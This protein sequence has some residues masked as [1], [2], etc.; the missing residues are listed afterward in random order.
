MTVGLFNI[1]IATIFA[2]EVLEGSII[3]INYRSIIHNKDDWDKARK[4]ESLRAVTVAAFLA[5]FVAT[6]VVICVAVPLGILG[7][8]LNDHIVSL[9]EGKENR[10]TSVP[11]TKERLHLTHLL[12]VILPLLLYDT[13]TG[14]SKLVATIFILHFSLKIPVWL[15]VYEK[16]PLCGLKQALK[17][18]LC[19]KQG[20]VVAAEEEKDDF[21]VLTLTEIRFNVMWNLWRE[22][23]ECGVFL[24]P[25]FLGSGSRAIPVSGIVGIAASIILATI[26]YQ[27]NQRLHNKG[28]LAFVMAG[29]TL[30]L[31]VGLFVGS[32]S[33][34]Q[35][36]AR[37][38]EEGNGSEES[39]GPYLYKVKNEFWA[40]DRFPMVLIQPFGYSDKRTVAQMCCFWLYLVF[41]MSLHWVMYSRSK[42][43]RTQRQALAELG[44][45]HPSKQMD[46]EAQEDHER[47]VD[48]Q[49]L[50]TS[51][52]TIP[53]IESDA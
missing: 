8:D 24:I 40:D 28:W 51:K 7:H 31:S 53:T 34:F 38:G 14:S 22:V 35:E 17:S 52:A 13:K 48:K 10:E 26:I 46:E 27:A 45:G 49:D 32:V 43:V 47:D 25:F 11:F 23:A 1:A 30:M 39:G 50:N 41:G 36:Q 15:G 3:V 6:I 16:V 20:R 18:M 21:N 2:R 9:V 12:T 5:T 37:G 44:S 42:Q 19:T 33:E 29:L 4:Q